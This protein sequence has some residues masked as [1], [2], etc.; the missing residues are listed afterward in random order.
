MNS[1]VLDLIDKLAERVKDGKVSRD[2]AGGFLRRLI[3][4][5]ALALVVQLTPTPLDDLALEFL[6]GAIPKA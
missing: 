6:R 2:D 3:H 1:K 5:P 4:G